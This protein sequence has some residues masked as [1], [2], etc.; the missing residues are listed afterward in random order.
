M[1]QL[2]QNSRSGAI[3]VKSVPAP[4]LKPGMVLVRNHFSLISA[5]TERMKVELGKKNLLGKAMARPD[6]VQQVLKQMKEMGVVSTLERAFNK[7][8]TDS[9]MGYSSAGTVVEVADDISE[10][11]VGD[12]VACAGGGYASHAEFVVVPKN[13]CAKIPDCVPFDEAAYSTLGA[14]AMQGLRQ[15][16]PTLGETVTVIGLGLLG[17]ILVQL[18]KANGCMVIGVDISD[19]ALRL[20][21]EHGCD[22]ALKRSAE[23]VPDQIKSF[24]N[25]FGTDAVI[26]TAS[27]SQNDPVEFAAEI[28]RDRGRVVMVG[29]TG[30]NLPRDPYYMKELD[31]KLSRSYGAGRYDTNYEEKGVDYPIGY[32]RWTEKRNM[33]TFVQLLAEKKIKLD[34]IT[35]HKFPIEQAEDAYKLISGE[36]QERYIGILLDYGEFG[37]SPESTEALLHT[38]SHHPAPSVDTPFSDK[39]KRIGMIGAGSFAQGFLIPNLAAISGVELAAVCNA[40]GINAENVKEKFGVGYATSNVE[41]LFSDENI[42]TVVIATRH[43]LH[44]EM[45]TKALKAGK[46]V[47][48]EKPLALTEA[49]LHEVA[50]AY[51]NSSAQLLTGFNRRFSEPVKVLKEFF[52]VTKEPMSVHYRVNAGPLPFDHWTQDLSEGGGRLIGEG[53]HFI[54]TIQ[55]LTGA[56]PVRVFAEMLPGAVRE[57]LCITIRFDN[58]SVG[59]VQY[60]CN[61][62]KLYPKERIEVFGG[63][64]IGIMENFKEVVLSSQG[65]QRKRE[66]DGGKGHKEE[67]AAFI[68]SLKT[69]EPAIDFRSQVLTTLATFRINQSLNSGM[70]EVI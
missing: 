50:E 59:V 65:A 18:L 49:E 43:N 70:P 10:F 54:D 68:R 45:V 21:K 61:G 33:Q 16:N 42:G 27:T 9:A 35:T 15:A 60:L 66:Y 37:F 26:I 31:F 12:R 3:K 20:A 36:V 5:G 58:G 28:M 64:R 2:V 30:M 34:K 56:E 57:N 8:N 32:V 11:R 14:I 63:G 23:N 44:A 40:T 19:E 25:G 38:A 52:S 51:A 47:F 29:V 22:L 67:M 4:S 55:Y 41:E 69:G 39:S 53:C 1:Q 48:V 13:L 62:D 6:Q 7:L 24:T 17:Q 46:H